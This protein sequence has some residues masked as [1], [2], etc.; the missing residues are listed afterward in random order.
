MAKRDYY[1]VLGISRSASPDELKAAYRRQAIKFHPDKNPG[2][3]DAAEKF[4]EVNEAYSV[5]SN[6]QK[7][8]TYD[9]FGHAGVQGAG[10]APGG[11]F[12]FS[13][14]G[15][16][17]EDVFGEAFGFGRG[18]RQGRGAEPGRDLRADHEVNLTEVLTGSEVSLNV[19]AFQACEVCSGSGAAAGSGTKKCPDC[20]GS[21]QL[22]VSHGFFSISQTC[23]R[24]RGYGEVID[25]PCPA[26]HG[27]GRVHKNKRVKVRIPPGVETGTTLRVSSEGEAG[28]RGAPPGDLYVVIQVRPDERFER[29]GA[30]L[31]TDFNISFPLAALGGEISVP[32]LENPVRLKIPAGTQPGILF[33]IA[34]HGLP[35]LKNRSRGDLFVRIKVEVP[36]KLSK[37]D[38]KIISDLAE[39]LGEDRISKDD[40]VFKRV[41]GG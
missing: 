8:Q 11:G 41:F 3:K 16:I 13:S 37:E 21:G 31:F 24:C 34:E 38:R 26:C 23:G 1:E 35:H 30:N 7:R 5:L 17:F 4:K 33:R 6:P 40:G 19:P 32:T 22:R 36:K 18:R 29:E 25:K 2:N 28:V 12:D 39:R 10:G 27:Q 15:D 20:G 14:F 9:Q